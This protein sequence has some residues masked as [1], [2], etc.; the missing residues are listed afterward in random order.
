MFAKIFAL[1]SLLS[2]A[3]FA[4][5]ARVSRATSRYYF[6]LITCQK[7]LNLT[8]CLFFVILIQRTPNGIRRRGP[9]NPYIHTLLLYYLNK[10]SLINAQS[11][12]PPNPYTGSIYI[13]LKYYLILIT[14]LIYCIRL[15]WC[16]SSYWF[17]G[18]SRTCY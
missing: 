13:S 6:S 15:G 17:L 1:S 12:P 10:H 7:R 16:P 14:T 2:A 4:P 5:T 9:C 18:P 8:K 3:A 11:N